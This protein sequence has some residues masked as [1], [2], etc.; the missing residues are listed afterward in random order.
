[1]HDKNDVKNVGHPDIIFGKYK[2]GTFTKKALLCQNIMQ[3]YINGKYKEDDNESFR[4]WNLAKWLLEVNLEF[5]NHFKELST[6]NYTTSN[7]IEYILRRIKHNVEK[8]I[9]VGIIMQVRT[10]KETKGTG[11]IPIF[12]F[13]TLGRVMAWVVESMNPGRREHAVSQ[14]YELFQNHYKK[15]PSSID[16]FCS[17]YYRKCKERG[18]FGDLIEHYKKVV[19]VPVPMLGRYGFSYHLML[20]PKYNIDSNIDFRSLW[21]DSIAELEP[22]TRELIFQHI[23]LEIERKAEAECHA[24]GAF[25]KKRFTAKNIP[26]LVTVEGQCMNCGL[27]TPCSF[28]LDN[29]MDMVYEAYPNGVIVI[30]CPA[31]KK[32]GSVEF[33]VLM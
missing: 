16:I 23:K 3:Y 2:D 5:I 26:D 8:L 15:E 22:K 33:P 7:R 28:L 18:I 4:L 11:T 20:I 14:I 13:T 19:G 25:E 6:R 21:N 32:D 29:Y 10:E 17:I 1:M 27:Y 31:C 30:T 24:F 9:D 12:Q